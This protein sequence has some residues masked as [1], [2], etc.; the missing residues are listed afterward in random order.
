MKIESEVPSLCHS[1]RKNPRGI[2][3]S[4]DLKKTNRIVKIIKTEKENLSKHIT[5]TGKSKRFSSPFT[6]GSRGWPRV[7]GR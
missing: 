7:V 4:K 1:E 6:T 2:L 3:Q 5:K